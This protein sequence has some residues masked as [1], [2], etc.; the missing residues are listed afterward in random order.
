MN[1]LSSEAH[2][3]QGGALARGCLSSSGA[4]W[5]GLA[6]HSCTL[7]NEL[8][9]EAHDGRGGALARGCMSSSGAWWMGTW[10]FTDVLGKYTHTKS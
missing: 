8:G 5:M 3:G 10:P 6:I 1:Q 7:L 4:W 2:D 9:S